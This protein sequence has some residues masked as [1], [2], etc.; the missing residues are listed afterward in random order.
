MWKNDAL[1]RASGAEMAADRFKLSVT[2]VYETTASVGS[3]FQR[4]VDLYGSESIERLM[5]AVLKALQ[6]LESLA[7]AAEETDGEVKD[8]KLERDIAKRDLAE[9]KRKQRQ[10][11]DEEDE[12]YQ[13]P[14]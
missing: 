1:S 13:S 5:P 9:E 11:E 10:K 8:L 6:Q 4:F 3:E 12:T 2:D 14:S 7:I